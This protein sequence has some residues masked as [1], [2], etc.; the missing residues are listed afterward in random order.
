M[1]TR[2]ST[3]LAALFVTLTFATPLAAQEAD[4]AKEGEAPA[5]AM[6]EMNNEMTGEADCSCPCAGMQSMHQGMMK[7]DSAG[8]SGMHGQKGMKMG[9][10][11]GMAGD[12][13]SM[14]AGM[15]AGMDSASHAAM[16]QKHQEMMQKH[17]Q[18]KQDCDC[19]NG[20]NMQ[21]GM[22]GQCPMHGQGADGMTM[23]GEGMQH[24]HGMESSD[25]AST[26]GDDSGGN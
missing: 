17:Q 4:A 8:M 23:Q 13:A 14:R 22:Q 26:D 25:E 20:E 11:K 15:D 6:N 21:A 1:H 2:R 10:M 9:G 12:S 3:A 19:Q 16:M 5:A 24:R 7:S 18:M